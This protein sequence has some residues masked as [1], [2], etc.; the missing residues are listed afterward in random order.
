MYRTRFFTRSRRPIFAAA[1]YV[2]IGGLWI[3]FSDQFVYSFT[4]NETAI[5]LMQMLKGWFFVG[6]T[7]LGLYILL[8]RFAQVE[9]DESGLYEGLFQSNSFPM[10]IIDP[11]TLDIVE[12]NEAASVFY[13]YDR[14][15]LRSMSI[16]EINVAVRNKVVSDA[17]NASTFRQNI[18]HFTHLLANGERRQV[19]VHSSPLVIGGKTYLHSIISD[20]TESLLLERKLAARE[21]LLDSFLSNAPTAMH[22]VGEDGT[23]TL[24]NQQWEL[25]TGFRAEDALGRKLDTLFRP[26]QAAGILEINR[27]ILEDN[28]P[29]ES[30]AELHFPTGRRV[31]RS[32][33]FP[34]IDHDGARAVGG[35][36]MDITKELEAE[37]HLR[38][39]RIDAEAANKSKSEFLTNMSH[40]IRTPLN[41]V[42][43]MLQLLQTTP[44]NEEQ[45]H[46]VDIAF[47]SNKRLTTLL[48]DILDLSR[49]EAGRTRVCNESFDVLETLEWMG[50]LFLPMVRQKGVDLSLDLDPGL[51]RWLIGDV[52]HL[53]QVLFNLLGNAFKF[54][55]KGFVSL[56]ASVLP[57]PKKGF[58]QLLLSVRDTGIGVSD[59]KIELLFQSF[60]QAENTFTRRFQGAGLG[61][62][63]VARLVGLMGG[64]LHVESEEGKGSSFHL[65]IPFGVDVARNEAELPA[66]NAPRAFAPVG[67]RVLVAEDDFVSMTALRNML[68]HLGAEV[69]GAPD[70]RQAI[71]ALREGDYDLVFMDIQMP[72]L[73]GLE[74]V[75]AIRNGQA[76]ERNTHLPVVALTSYAMTGDRERFLQAGFDDYIAKPVEREVLEQVLR[77]LVTAV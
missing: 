13:G 20:E 60:T 63:I 16:G 24:V 68:V 69:R 17:R 59:E 77:Q 55:E 9:R 75:K 8:Q 52:Q 49:I 58:C 41:G 46:Y 73:N 36:S 71:E 29:S 26:E 4:S 10:F 57:F 33:K 66:T 5:Y 47:V 70:G 51:P 64:H 2:A 21:R 25:D 22:V 18:F 34:L 15:T 3:L 42:M 72:T 76:G 48:S 14:E 40:E 39:A 44:L 54:T 27:K 6:A 35:V 1:V 61:L 31:Y 67:G 30:R 38:R 53:R 65:N 11:E 7:G 32:F 50:E 62:A 74:A 43:G 23:L 37:E 28:R 19:V 56:E 12:A 45:K